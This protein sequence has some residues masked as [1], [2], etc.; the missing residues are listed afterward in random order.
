MVVE[1]S[2]DSSACPRRTGRTPSGL[3]DDFSS[4]KATSKTLS[5]QKYAQGQEAQACGAF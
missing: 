5:R 4:L 3:P 2:R 1:L